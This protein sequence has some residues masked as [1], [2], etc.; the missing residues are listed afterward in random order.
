MENNNKNLKVCINDRDTISYL[1]GSNNETLICS[2]S[3]TRE[4]SVYINKV[5]NQCVESC[6][7]DLYI[8][9]IFC[10]DKCPKST[11]EKEIENYDC[12]YGECK[13]TQK[14]CDISHMNN[15]SYFDSKT[16][17]KCFD[18]CKQCYS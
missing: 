15:Y 12:P 7:P 8:Y 6:D 11:T 17:I 14:I 18:N 9:D 1:L 10:Y 13:Q 3:C 4:K 2:H 5:K 16:P